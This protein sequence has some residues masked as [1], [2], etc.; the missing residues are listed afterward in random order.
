MH[1]IDTFIAINRFGLGSS[2]KDNAFI[3]DNPKAWL[4][5]QIEAG[6]KTPAALKNFRPSAA[7]Y[8]DIQTAIKTKDRTLKRSRKRSLIKNDFKAEVFAK[9]R[10]H[11]STKQPFTERLV[12]FWSNHFTVSSAKAQIAPAI[13][14]YEREQIRP[15]IY[16]KFEDLLIAAIAHPTMLTYLDNDKSIG[17]N[18]TIG[19]RRKKSFNE[20]LAREILELHTL[21]V[22]G[23]YLQ[24]DIIEL[25]KIITGWTHDGFLSRRLSKK[26]GI[27]GK[28]AFRDLLHEPGVKTVLGKTY[29]ED[30]VKEGIAVLKDLARHPSTAKFIATKLAIHF[31]SDE[32]KNSTIDKL[33]KVYL[34]TNGDLSKVYEAIIDLPQVWQTPLPKVKTPYEFII[35]TLRAVNPQK[36]PIRFFAPPLTAMAHIPYS[37][38]SPQGWPDKAENWVAPETLLRRIEWARAISARLEINQTPQELL[39]QT[40]G[41]VANSQTIEMVEAA[42]SKDA[43]M[44]IIFSSSEFQRR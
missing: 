37:A 16:G 6:S 22:N 34:K 13:P 8:K 44:A 31:V 23:G 32:P 11:V 17:P 2:P 39:E 14:A 3:H 43:A 25:A 24:N 29:E 28:F 21:G 42:P 5:K 20:N 36:L 26:T 18:S 33:A 1:D 12:S 4:Q 35:S 9:A 41:V 19:K 15:N 27:E 7:I 30:G 40:I 10:Y 38:N